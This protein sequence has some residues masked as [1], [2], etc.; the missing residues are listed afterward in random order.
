MVCSIALHPF[1]IATVIGVAAAFM[2]FTPPAPVESL[3]AY[4]AQAAAPCALFAMGVT[5]ALRPLNRVPL[6]LGYI[7]PMKL[8]VHPV[9]MYL[10]L[11]YAGSFDP[12]WVFTAILMA[13]LPTATN[14]F[15]I[16]QQ[17][18]VWVERVSAAVLVT[19]ILSVF[20][21][22]ALLYAIKS[23]A[24]PPDLIP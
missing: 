4:L 9:L 1:I 15:V 12:V 16:A 19:T 2:N 13:A 21:V 6:E 5:L 10:A 3:I 23:G 20:T 18:G 11:S 8:I 7:V 24:L 22:S 14:V 17:Y